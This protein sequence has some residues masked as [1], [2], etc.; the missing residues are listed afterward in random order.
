LR[1]PR[2]LLMDEAT[3]AID[4]ATER[5]MSQALETLARNRT[6]ITIAHRLSTVRH[7][8]QII[9]RDKG[10]AVERG[11]HDGLLALNGAYA[12]LVRSPH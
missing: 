4:T 7:A 8:D 11:T 9:V 10:R 1:N 12:E 5:A 6:T 2:V 3:S